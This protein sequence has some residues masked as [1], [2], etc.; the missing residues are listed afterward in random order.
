MAEDVVALLGEGEL[1]DRVVDESR[2]EQVA[3]VA[4]GVAAVD[5]ALHV[6][7]QPVN[8]LTTCQTT[9]THALNGPLSRMTPDTGTRKAKPIWGPNYKIS[10]DLC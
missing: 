9:N 1:V 3:R 2:L 5:K 8:H 4:A 10:H 6:T 7:V